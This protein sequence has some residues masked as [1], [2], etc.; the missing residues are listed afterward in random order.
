MRETLSNLL[1]LDSLAMTVSFKKLGHIVLKNNNVSNMP[2]MN[3]N[4]NDVLIYDYGSIA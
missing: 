2:V 4:A 1:N 3:F